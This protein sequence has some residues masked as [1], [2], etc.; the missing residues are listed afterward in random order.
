MFESYLGTL[1]PEADPVTDIITHTDPCVILRPLSWLAAERAL[2]SLGSTP[3]VL[4]ASVRVCWPVA[5]PPLPCCCSHTSGVRCWPSVSPQSL[6]LLE[7]PL[8]TASNHIKNNHAMARCAGHQ[9]AL[10]LLLLLDRISRS[11]VLHRSVPH[12]GGQ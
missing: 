11:H 1:R 8:Y 9:W 2:A 4:A 6:H 10:R 12:R 7:G 3:S 5:S